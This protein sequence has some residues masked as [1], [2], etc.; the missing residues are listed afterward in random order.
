MDP[1]DPG[2][3]TG[4]SNRQIDYCNVL[5]YCPLVSLCTGLVMEY[6]KSSVECVGSCNKEA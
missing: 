5:I 4:R 2:N 1:L 6:I 3:G